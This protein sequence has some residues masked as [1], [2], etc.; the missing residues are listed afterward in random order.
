MLS[1]DPYYANTKEWNPD[2]DVPTFSLVLSS[3][4]ATDGKKHVDLYTHKGLLHRL[5]GIN[6]LAKF[7]DQDVEKVRST[8][9]QYQQDAAQGKDQWGKTSFRGVPAEDLDKEVFFAGT[10]TPVLHYCMGGITIDEEGNVLD[11]NGHKIPGLH[12]AGEV[13]GGVHGSNRLG[14]NSLLECTVFGTIVGK[15][16]PIADRHS[17]NDKKPEPEKAKQKE[18]REVSM[19]ELQK[20]NTPDDCWV[21]IGGMVYDLTDFAPE[22]PSGAGAKSI[23]ALA[24]KDGTVAFEAVHSA[25]LLKEFDDD[26]IGPLLVG[27]EDKKPSGDRSITVDELKAHNTTDDCWVAFHGDVFD[28][29]RF[30]KEHPGGSHLIERLAGSDGTDRFVSVHGKQKLEFVKE[31]RVGTLVET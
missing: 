27:D 26:R 19:E 31:D 22:H 23:H 24:G 3:S 17:E 28:M 18:L 30:A 5:E 13:T 20:H 15:K 12:A 6:E 2:S 8:L 21:A 7:M 11:E 14:G 29:T 25:G 9:V 1:H 10:V 4:A 16:L